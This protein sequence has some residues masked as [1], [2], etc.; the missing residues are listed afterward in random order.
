MNKFTDTKQK[1]QDWIGNEESWLDDIT[2]DQAEEILSFLENND[3]NI[4]EISDMNATA[5]FINNLLFSEE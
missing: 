1:I 5:E 3:I 2:E 4:E